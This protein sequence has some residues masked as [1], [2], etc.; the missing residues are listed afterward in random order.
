[1]TRRISW[2]KAWA[3]LACGSLLAHATVAAPPMNAFCQP[4]S[5]RP[6]GTLPDGR[7]VSL[8][9]LE[10]PGGWKAEVTDYGAI[11]VA[12]H[13]PPAPGTA[14][15]PVDV[16]LGFDT[17]A[18]YLGPHPYF[19]A[20]VGRVANRIAGGRF[21]L[22]GKSY[23][24]ARNNG[25]NH[26]HGGLVGFD[27]K[28]WRATPRL[29]DRGPAVDFEVTSPDGDEGYPG[30]V[31]ARVTYTL[32][33]DGELWVEMSATTDAPTLVN[34]AHHSYWNLAGQASGT[35]LDHELQVAAD[36]YLPV[37]ATS[38]P[39]GAIAPVADTPFDLRTARPLGS[40]VAALPPSADGA[41][42]GGI[43]HNYLVR[44]WRPEGGLVS[45]ATLR[46]PASG[47]TL[48]ILSDQP[49]IQVYTAN[50][51]DGTLVGKGGTAY[52]KQSA[53]CLETQ[54]SPDSVHHPDW[55]T[56]RLE[57]GQTYRHTLVHRFGHSTPEP[58]R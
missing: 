40:A 29:S 37:D 53:I 42:Q 9:V 20:T 55:P 57:P 45:V 33:P 30:A 3:A 35:I 39:T 2:L 10:V 43:D 17:L 28:L 21:D 11:L 36:A 6:F 24:L 38:I 5:T 48:E 4:P 13:V 14:A 51:L 15:Q 16:V 52:R 12:M 32:S 8:Y 7:G 58:A 1:M 56:T 25:P 46:D 18:G 23:T 54:R 22:D 31:T 19:G 49:G 44:G 26:L 50:Y 34:L 47:R 27:K 41:N